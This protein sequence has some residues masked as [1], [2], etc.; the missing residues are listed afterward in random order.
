MCGSYLLGVP[1]SVE[2]RGQDDSLWRTLL[3]T[4][5]IGGPGRG[6]VDGMAVIGLGVPGAK[7]ELVPFRLGLGFLSAPVGPCEMAGFST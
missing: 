2:K 4:W 1:D 7:R 6:S 3:E 5:R